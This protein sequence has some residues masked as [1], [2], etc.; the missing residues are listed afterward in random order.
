M[1]APAEPS[2]GA[3]APLPSRWPDLR[4]RVL[5]AALLIPAAILCIWLGAEAWA[6]LM[7]AA[8][9]LLAWEWVRLC[10]FSTRRLPGLAVPVLVLAAGTL[11]VEAAWALA[12]GL[13]LRRLR[14][15]LG[16]RSSCRREPRARS[17]RLACLRR[18]L[19]RSGRHRA[20]PSARR[21]GG[22]AGQCAVP[23]PGGLGQRYRR[24]PG[25][26]APSAGR[27][28]RRP[29]RPTRPGPGR[30]GGLGLGHAG[31]AA[32]RRGDRPL[33]LRVAAVPGAAGRRR[34]RRCW[35]SSATCSRA[36]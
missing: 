10:G 31:R 24:L 13:L 15:A 3:A 32:G 6:A 30:A 17:G 1:P 9:A 29:S 19:Y 2:V 34:A 35:R 7:A 33:G 14:G 25:R 21:C 18:A 23:V 28:W 27:S 22:R 8:V 36:G 12:L 20:D 11:A 16:L 4:K 26:A 5:S